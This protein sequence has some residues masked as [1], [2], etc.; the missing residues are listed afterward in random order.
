MSEEKIN[1]KF[2]IMM[3]G[4][5]GV[6]KTSITRRF[7]DQQFHNTYIHTIGIDFLEKSLQIQEERIL[8]QIWDTAGQDRY[9]KWS[10][11]HLQ[12]CFAH[13]LY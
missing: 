12:N 5:A 8:L 4:D 3:L 11:L 10:P 6:G 13:G 7:V 2:K 1:H 9:K